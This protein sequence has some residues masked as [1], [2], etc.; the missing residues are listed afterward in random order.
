MDEENWGQNPS[1]HC[2]WNYHVQTTFIEPLK[3]LKIGLG[4]LPQTCWIR[5]SWGPGPGICILLAPHLSPEMVEFE[6]WWNWAKS[7]QKQS[8]PHPPCNL[9]CGGFKSPSNENSGSLPLFSLVIFLL[10]TQSPICFGK[11]HICDYNLYLVVMVAKILWLYSNNSKGSFALFR[12][13]V[14]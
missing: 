14:N 6:A 12:G 1:H 8:S 5:P 10:L 2:F 13:G 9:V 11:I 3:S 4:T 7:P